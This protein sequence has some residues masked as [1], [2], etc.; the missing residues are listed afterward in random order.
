MKDARQVADNPYAKQRESDI[1]DGKVVT[2][3][4]WFEQVVAAIVNS[5]LLINI[6]SKIE[7][8]SDTEKLVE[9]INKADRSEL[10]SQAV[11]VIEG[12]PPGFTEEIDAVSN[13][14]YEASNQAAWVWGVALA[15][16]CIG[17]NSNG[18]L[19]ATCYLIARDEVSSEA[20]LDELSSALSQEG[21]EYIYLALN[22]M[23]TY[24]AEQPENYTSRDRVQFRQVVLEWKAETNL[25]EVWSFRAFE[26]FQYYCEPIGVLE[27]VRRSDP[28]RYL[29]LLEVTALPPVIE[30][31]FSRLDISYDFDAILQL[32][33]I[34]PST[35]ETDGDSQVWNRKLIAPILLER[36]LEHVRNVAD[37]IC[38]SHGEELDSAESIRD[39]DVLS[40]IR[41]LTEVLLERQDGISLAVHWMCYLIG[42]NG[43]K[44]WGNPDRWSPIPNAVEAMASGLYSKGITFEDIESFFPKYAIPK[45]D[46][47]IKFRL[48]G[49]GDLD[50]YEKPSGLD[51]LLAY[52]W[53]TNQTERK[54]YSED[55]IALNFFE[56]L[57]V[58]QDC[59]LFITLPEACPTDREYY[60]AL[61]YATQDQPVDAWTKSW[62]LL[63]EQRRLFRHRWADTSVPRSEDSSFFLANV[64]LAAVDW[65]ISPEIAKSEQALRLYRVIFDTVFNIVITPPSFNKERWHNLIAKLFCRLPHVSAHSDRSSLVVEYLIRLGGDD[66]LFI[67]SLANACQ[68][69][70]NIGEVAQK[71]DLSG[72]SLKN[73]LDAYVVWEE[74]E[75]NRRR[76]DKMIETCMKLLQE[77]QP[78]TQES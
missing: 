76:N 8:C 26:Y 18:K 68:N 27:A 40:L 65:L 21:S 33:S 72:N 30:G 47:L 22:D 48:S 74:R 43:P 69:G 2:L 20:F 44:P 75:S 60:P 10:P 1:A 77:L 6:K 67:W 24:I 42:K 49:I 51:I 16:I 13:G 35:F 17:A 61:L 28:V 37:V 70:A 64:G 36:G 50:K 39:R 11:A 54:S 45:A 15:R 31:A 78:Q 9:Q 32:L 12:L 7:S 38:R 3:A 5:P 46:D 71:I 19:L 56:S 23:V 63:A 52:F 4:P 58:R 41:R 66:E 57:L 62:T 34:A 73:R 29:Q 53:I 55:E 25:S 14:D 59:G